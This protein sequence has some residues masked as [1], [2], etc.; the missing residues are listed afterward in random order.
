LSLIIEDNL[1]ALSD[2]GLLLSTVIDEI[3]QNFA[4]PI[5]LKPLRRDEGRRIDLVKYPEY[6]KDSES[7][8]GDANSFVLLVSLLLFKDTPTNVDALPGLFDACRRCAVIVVGDVSDQPEIAIARKVIIQASDGAYLELDKDQGVKTFLSYGEDWLRKRTEVVYAIHDV[9]SAISR[10]QVCASW[11]ARMRARDLAYLRLMKRINEPKLNATITDDASSHDNALAADAFSGAIRALIRS[12]GEP[13]GEL[14]QEASNWIKL[15][16][17]LHPAPN[18]SPE[19]SRDFQPTIIPEPFIAELTARLRDKVKELLSIV[20][21]HVETFVNWGPLGPLQPDF[22]RLWPREALTDA[23]DKAIFDLTR[24]LSDGGGSAYIGKRPH[25]EGVMN[26]LKTALRYPMQ[27]AAPVAL[28]GAALGT[29]FG[30][31]ANSAQIR[32]GFAG[33]I[34]FVAPLLLIIARRRARN[35]NRIAAFTDVQAARAH[36]VREVEATVSVV[37]QILQDET[38][39]FTANLRD[40]LLLTTVDAPRDAARIKQEKKRKAH[41]IHMQSVEKQ[42]KV[43]DDFIKRL[44]TGI[45]RVARIQQKIIG[46]LSKDLRSV[47]ADAAKKSVQ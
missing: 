24:R 37:I 42:G 18:V 46:E 13:D 1:L 21:Y 29:V 15:L 28:F 30:L 34:V 12:A 25:E 43:L 23:T 35:D 39:K 44:N 31:S 17:R 3:E 32:K 40:K 19:E 2:E 9:R 26:V 5:E 20:G 16:V 10:A 27:V 41:E 36:L 47:L 4:P 7:R 33:S 8:S 45:D 38:V 14:R 22:H 11:L 6:A